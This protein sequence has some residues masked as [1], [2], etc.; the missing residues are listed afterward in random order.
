MGE[1]HARS[2]ATRAAKA[3]SST[4]PPATPDELAAHI[5]AAIDWTQ[6]NRDLNPANAIIIYAWNE[7]DE[8][9]WLQ[10]TLGSDGKADEARIKALGKILRL[11]SVTEAMRHLLSLLA[12]LILTALH[13]AESPLPAE[14]KTRLQGTL[15]RHLNELLRED[16]SIAEMKGK[17]SKGMVPWRSI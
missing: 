14:F 10:P 13:A 8:G 4:P 17:T 16:G 2:H 9:G 12:T 7:H 5:R 1:R 11:S 3:T 15:V 6:A